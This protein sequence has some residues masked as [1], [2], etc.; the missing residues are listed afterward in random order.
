MIYSLVRMCKELIIKR[1]W[2]WPKR[3]PTSMR[4]VILEDGQQIR[5]ICGAGRSSASGNDSYH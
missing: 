4:I 5:G 2:A 1:L 3:R